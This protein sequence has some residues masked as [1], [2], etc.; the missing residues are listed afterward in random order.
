MTQVTVTT[1]PGDGGSASV[2]IVADNPQTARAIASWSVAVA[3]R[4]PVEA[5]DACEGTWLRADDAWTS[6]AAT[7]CDEVVVHVRTN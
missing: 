7:S 3:S 6:E 4:W 2:R 1:E 5:V